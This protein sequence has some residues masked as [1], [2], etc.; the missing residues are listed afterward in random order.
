MK[1]LILF[2]LAVLAA[3]TLF[4]GPDH[5]AR[6]LN[7]AIV[8]ELHPDGSCDMTYE[9]QVRLD[10]YYAFNRAL[11][12]TF[13]VT[14]PDFQKL[15]ILKAET[16]MAN[17]RKVAAPPNAF[18]EVL[19]F[20]AHGFA[21]FAHLR[22]MVITHTGLERGAL[23]DLKYRIHTRAGFLPVFSGREALGRDFPVDKYTLEIVVPAGRQLSF[24]A[25]GLEAQPEVK[26]SESGAEKKYSFQFMGLKP[27]A[28]EP[29]SPPPGIP[30]IVF[31]AAGD[32]QQVLALKEDLGPLPAALAALVEKLKTQYPSRPDLLAALQKTV[33]SEMSHCGLG[34]E[35]TGWRARPLQ[36]IFQSNYATRLEKA[37]LLQAMFKQAG[38]EAG[39]LGVADSG[40]FAANV[41]MPLQLGEFWLKVNDGPHALYLDPARE[42]HEFFPYVLAGRD[43]WNFSGQALEKLPLSGWEQNGVDISGTVRIDDSGASGDLVVSV[44]G[45]FLRYNE[46]AT[47]S[48]RFLTGLLKKIFPV[49]KLEVRKVLALSRR[50]LRVEAGFNGKWLREAGSGYFLADFCRLP[51]LTENMVILERRETPLALEAP[52]KVSLQLDLRPGPGLDLEYSAPEVDVTNEAG[53]FSRKRVVQ[54]DGAIGFSE[55]CGIIHS[56]LR[57]E[58]Y[59]RLRQLLLPYFAPDYWLAFK[60]NK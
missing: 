57:P 47:D 24:A 34:I 45:I 1:R 9:H 46:A 28:R 40:W 6:Y 51:G 11:G 38:I 52:F 54:K 29:L 12:E 37:L 5:D 27:A 19:P 42:Q 10:T 53:Y 60:K 36:N 30:F 8:Y 56:P 17:G 14:N 35:A 23:I 7:L 3:W 41:P 39:I 33:A 21:D 26:V 18:N 43:A 59:P 49:D 15:E 50:E 55:T 32:W 20:A 13:I 22:E 58:L 4:A 31:A 25:R 44:R 16:T 48:G 2:S